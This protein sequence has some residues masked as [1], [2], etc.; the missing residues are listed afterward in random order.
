[1][2]SG[3][4]MTIGC[5][6]VW[7]SLFLTCHVVSE[8]PAVDINGMTRLPFRLANQNTDGDKSVLGED[9]YAGISSAF[10]SE[11]V[12]KPAMYNSKD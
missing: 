6:L 7:C 8:T 4:R 12:Q 5:W 2:L 11:Y 3:D 10:R 1:M 9:R